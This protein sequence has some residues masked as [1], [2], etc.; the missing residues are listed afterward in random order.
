MFPVLYSND[1]QFETTFKLVCNKLR[2][3][4][5]AEAVQKQKCINNKENVPQDDELD[6]YVIFK[7]LNSHAFTTIHIFSKQ[8]LADGLRVHPR[9]IFSFNI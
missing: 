7:F 5:A 2:A 4:R 9:H 1:C 6:R 8:E 3:L